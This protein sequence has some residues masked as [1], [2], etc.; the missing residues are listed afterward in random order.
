MAT[1]IGYISREMLRMIRKHKV[2]FLTPV[3]LVLAVMA[4]LVYYIG[5]GVILSFVYAGI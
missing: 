2:Y 5:P 3:L 1:K 4:F